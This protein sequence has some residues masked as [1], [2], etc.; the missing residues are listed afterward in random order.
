MSRYFP[1][2]PDSASRRRHEP[3]IKPNMARGNQGLRP[4]VE[5]NGRGASKQRRLL[6]N[7]QVPAWH[8]ESFILT[9][10]RPATHS[11][12]F[13]LESLAYLHNETANIYTHLIPALVS[14]VLATRVSW[15]FRT[16]F[17]TAT[18]SDRLV[19]EIYLATSVLCFAVSS[20][21]HTL[22]CHSR[23]YNDLWLRI[24]YV[25]IL[26]QILGSFVSGIY[27]GFYC[28]PQLQKLYW[29]M[30]VPPP[31]GILCVHVHKQPNL[32]SVTDRNTGF[33]DG[34]RRDKP[35][36]AGSQIPPSPDLQLCGD[37][38]FGL[39]SHPPRRHHVPIPPT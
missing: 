22:R 16:A 14:A 23:Y 19:F 25:A 13:C 7:A 33:C 2:A 34:F 17:P 8:A 36:A 38:L 35:P 12:K 18:R 11:V 27:I 39:C 10:Y 3:L 29:V 6:S 9:G 5:R 24:D 30:V 15:Y 20:L 21:Y 1:M 32:V 37:R 28:E 26:F 31:P 4:D